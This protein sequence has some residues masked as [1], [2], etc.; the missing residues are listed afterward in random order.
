M[1]FIFELIRN[2]SSYN[3]LFHFTFLFTISLQTIIST[4]YIN[5]LYILGLLIFMRFNNEC[6]QRTI[7]LLFTYG[8]Y[9]DLILSYSLG[10]SSM[11]FIYFLF[12]GQLSN[13]FIGKGGSSFQGYL[14]LGGLIFYAL[15]EFIYIF[16]SFNIFLKI[17]VFISNII[18]VLSIYFITKLFNAPVDSNVR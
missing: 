15:I 9:Q 11:V 8:F 14:Y 10:T 12:L 16:F 13:I 3:F 7:L 5:F 17:D 6:S 4:P 2:I 1:N 18:I